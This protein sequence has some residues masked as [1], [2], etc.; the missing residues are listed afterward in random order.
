MLLTI[1]SVVCRHLH[2]AVHDSQHEHGVEN[3]GLSFVDGVYAE[4]EY[5]VGC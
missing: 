2:G 4:G 3:G 1:G 5:E